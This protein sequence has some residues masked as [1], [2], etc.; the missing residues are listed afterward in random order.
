MD[1]LD[2]HREQLRGIRMQ[3]WQRAAP[4]MGDDPD[5]LDETTRRGIK[6]Q[7]QE[8]SS[9]STPWNEFLKIDD[10]YRRWWGPVP[11]G[12]PPGEVFRLL[13]KHPEVACE[14]QLDGL[15]VARIV[16]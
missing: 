5:Q 11:S 6:L 12:I 10:E 9:P 3:A 1:R 15:A 16:P 4:G 14:L 13:L 7:M 8:E 2:Q